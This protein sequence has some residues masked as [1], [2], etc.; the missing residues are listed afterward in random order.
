MARIRSIK[1]KFWDDTKLSKISRDARLLFIGLWNFADDNGVLPA[2]NVWIKSKIFPFDQIQIKQ[3]EAWLQELRINGFISQFSHN[4]EDFYYLP[5]F[6][7]HQVINRPNIDDVF[8]PKECINISL[9]NHGAITEQSLPDRI[10]EERKGKDIVNP[11]L[12]EVEDYFKDK[13][14][15][16][17]IARKAYHYY[18]ENQWK[19]SNGNRVKNWKQKM[20]GV[21]FKP[22]NLD[23]TPV[24]KEQ[25]DKDRW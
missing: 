8:V 24:K 16:L 11:S 2:N 25:T 3:F 1:P 17:E 5:N 18:N 19:D 6:S 15:R 12:Q 21:W 10:G 7:K 22:E 23:T 13:G 14:Y 20:I 4:S 9:I